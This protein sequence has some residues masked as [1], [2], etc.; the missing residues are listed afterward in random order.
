M[1][2]ITN[3][4]TWVDQT[5][6]PQDD[7]L[8][9][10][11]A[12]GN[13]GIIYG[14]HVTQKDSGTLH[15]AAGH[16]ILCGRKFTIFDGDIPVQLSPT[17]TLLGRLYLSLDLSNAT[18]PI[19]L[20]VETGAVLTPPVQEQN[21]N[22]TNGIFE[23]NMATFT[24]DP[25]TISSV[26][27]VFPMVGAASIASALAQSEQSTTATRTYT[28]G[29]FV[30]ISGTL[31]EVTSA[32]AIGDDITQHATTTTM[33]DAVTGAHTVSQITIALTDWSASTTTVSGKE[34]YT[35]VKSVTAVHVQSPDVFIGAS[36]VIPTE[37]EQAAYNALSYVVADDVANTLT[38]Y[39]EALPEAAV[40]VQVRG[41][42]A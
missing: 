26:V 23:I 37:A 3:L 35:A 11:S 27:N 42:T 18:A 20:L 19:Q 40:V 31:Y 34:Y 17:G 5:V 1:A 6:T 8:V 10:E 2:D 36:G 38:F 15:I 22:I 41:V 7:A 32:I 28:P 14:C 39:A 29:D 25:S 13:G 4:V 12:L 30:M 21:I 9:Y 24:V 16:G 33:G